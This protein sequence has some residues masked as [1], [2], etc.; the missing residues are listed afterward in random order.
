MYIQY[1]YFKQKPELTFQKSELVR[2]T[3]LSL[4]LEHKKKK[5]KKAE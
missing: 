2:L 3:G 5:K 1:I 4:K